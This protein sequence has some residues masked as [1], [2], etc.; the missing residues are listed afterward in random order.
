[1]NKRD[2]LIYHDEMNE[3]IKSFLIALPYSYD[4]QSRKDYW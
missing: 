3:N 4:Y 1:M 2:D